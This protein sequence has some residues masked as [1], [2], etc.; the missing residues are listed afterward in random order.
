M[1]W[2][3]AFLPFMPKEIWAQP[4]KLV[5]TVIGFNIGLAFF[6]VGFA[7]AI[8]CK[9]FNRWMALVFIGMALEFLSLGLIYLLCHPSLKGQIDPSQAWRIL[10]WLIPPLYWFSKGLLVLVSVIPTR[11]WIDYVCWRMRQK[12]SS[13]PPP[14]LRQE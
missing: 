3:F 2:V 4:E 9:W 5:L 8:P 1:I 7:L 11:G 14:F 12:R 13:T 6:G 10:N